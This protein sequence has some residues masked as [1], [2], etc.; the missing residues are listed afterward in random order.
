MVLY[1][2]SNWF[3]PRRIITFWKWFQ[4]SI[5][6]TSHACES[7][8]LFSCQFTS[9][10]QFLTPDSQLWSSHFKSPIY[11]RKKLDPI[12]ERNSSC[13]S[14][15][16]PRFTDFE[17][18]KAWRIVL[19]QSI[20]NAL[21]NFRTSEFF[22]TSLEVSG[23]LWQRSVNCQKLWHSTLQGSIFVVVR[24]SQMT[25]KLYGEVKK[26]QKS[27]FGWVKFYSTTISFQNF[28][29]M[30]PC[31]ITS[32]YLSSDHFSSTWK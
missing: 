7:K 5:P 23:N 15:F 9:A 13:K 4:C 11:H 1:L 29:T 24:S 18:K 31:A 19:F 30:L 21:W 6:A 10:D 26:I 8:T 27:S 3:I 2:A 17:G 25:Q 22:R 20:S 14:H 16:N 12:W 28:N 32:M